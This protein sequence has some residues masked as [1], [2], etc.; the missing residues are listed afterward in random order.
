MIK[1]K[2]LYLR[3]PLFDV[4]LKDLWMVQAMDKHPKFKGRKPFL[5]KQT[6]AFSK[7]DI[8]QRSKGDKSCIEPRVEAAGHWICNV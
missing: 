6:C 3:L 2:K 8:E 1:C 5:K 7:I 4:M